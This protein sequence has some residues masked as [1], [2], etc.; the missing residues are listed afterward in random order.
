MTHARNF[1]RAGALV[2]ALLL[3][4]AA[5]AFANPPE[6]TLTSPSAGGSLPTDLPSFQGLTSDLLDPLSVQVY[7]GAAATGTPLLTIE[8]TLGPAGEWSATATE[9]LPDGRYTAV[10]EQSELGEV[11]LSAPVTFT[12][13]TIAPTVTL[14]A[15]PAYTDKQATTLTGQLGQ[16]PGDVQAVTVTI[17][18][19]ATVSGAVRASE[20]AAV[21][22]SSWSYTTPDLPEGAYTIRAS[23]QDEAG[24]VGYSAAGHLT[25]DL[26]PPKVS[27]T[28]PPEL[29]TVSKPSLSGQAGTAAGDLPTVTLDVYRS[30]M[31][32]G[33]GPLQT[34]QVNAEGG[35]WSTGASGLTLANGIYTL[36]A[37]QEDR[38][39]N[40][41]NSAAVSF[42]VHSSA[43]VVTLAHPDLVQRESEG[44]FAGPGPRFEGTG[45]T[46]PEAAATVRLNLYRGD[47]TSPSA[48]IESVSVPL[49]GETWSS[50]LGSALVN[51]RIYTVQA[52]QE[53]PAG[54]DPGL[55]Q[56]VKFTVDAD[57]P[58]VTLAVPAEGASLSGGG[59]DA[60]GSAG[61]APGDEPEV[62]VKLFAGDAAAGSPLETLSVPRSGGSWSAPLGA[63]APG[64]Y[65]VLAQQS[66]DVGN[67]GASAPATFTVVEPGGP[68]P[69]SASFSW[70][71]SSPRVGET[72]SL[73]STSTD[74]TSAIVGY[75][76]DLA[77]TGS[78]AAGAQTASTSFSTPGQHAVELMVTDALGAS[79]AVVESIPVSAQP[80]VL[81]QPF[82]VVRIA[83]SETAR[84]VLIKLLT[85]QAPAG[86]TI[87][88]ACRGRGCPVRKLVALA[89]ARRSAA[90]QGAALVTI[91]RFERRLPAGVILE[92]R[93]AKA[94]EIGKYTKFVTRRGRLPLRTDSC[95]TPEGQPMECP[96]A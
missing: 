40:V 57:P 47:S 4:A 69:P 8:A 26:T 7:A 58:A 91:H 60:I 46:D 49:A 64:A 89:P 54:E 33:E 53:G 39:G 23:Q 41:G 16:A 18:E 66:D 81:M 24:N 76:W 51:G 34:V 45:S 59:L 19:G 10:A 93:V 78:L 80:L 37:Q 28:P 50:G 30:P 95:L 9:A 2:V 94:G 74:P 15:P 56:P 63:L 82:P 17:Y 48:R 83:G 31:Q 87:T 84:N 70:F 85:V 36:I 90:G 55:S 67:V 52:E 12:L 21:S 88:V 68:P 72:V 14:Q 27:I 65:T 92:V 73:V 35:S 20:A 6:L 11:G 43:P 86:A 44:L 25:V 42:T 77:G 62:T 61:I 96:A 71:P 75:D 1:A 32:E 5:P 3:A 79:G 38:A 29:F 22:G 13:D